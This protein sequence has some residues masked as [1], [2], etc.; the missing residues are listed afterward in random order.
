[1]TKA[2]RAVQVVL[3]VTGVLESPK[4]LPV[5]G[6]TVGPVV[7]AGLV[8]PELI[9]VHPS[10]VLLVVLAGLVVPVVLVGPVEQQGKALERPVLV[11]K[12]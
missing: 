11:S 6:V 2:L 5:P 1:V 3:V 10:R 8:E 12:V 9:T 7:P 4:V